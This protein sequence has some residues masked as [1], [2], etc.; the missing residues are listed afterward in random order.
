MSSYATAAQ[1]LQFAI[2]ATALTNSISTQDQQAACDAASIEADGYLT[3]QYKLPLLS[4]GTTLTV[5]V[6]NIAAYRLMGRRGYRPSGV[7]SGFKERYD[8]AISWLR[9]VSAGRITPPDITDSASGI[10]QGAP[11]VVSGVLGNTVGGN[12]SPTTQNLGSK[13]YAYTGVVPGQR[14]W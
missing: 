7:D 13:P 12:V 9:G 14:G 3:A 10:R 1:L 11:S 5:H 2:N 6:C 8:E 4:W